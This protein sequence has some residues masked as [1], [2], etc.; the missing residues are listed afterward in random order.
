MTQGLV[1]EGAVDDALAYLHT[2]GT[3][4][5]LVIA[6]P[7]WGRGDL[8]VNGRPVAADDPDAEALWVGFA[9][10]WL[11]RLVPLL[12]PTAAV[13]VLICEELRSTLR[14]LMKGIF[15]PLGLVELACEREYLLD[16]V[17]AS[18]EPWLL[19]AERGA[20]AG[21]EASRWSAHDCG[22]SLSD[23][24]GHGRYRTRGITELEL[25]IGRHNAFAAKPPA[26]YTTIISHWLPS[27]AGTVL[28]PFAG[29]GPL[30]IAANQLGIGWIALERQP[31]VQVLAAVLD[32][33]A[34]SYATVRL[35]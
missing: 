1:V 5:D 33:L 20:S 14:D 23:E 35:A 8:V 2:H 9:E 29:S 10:Q 26:L 15:T 31:E 30:A 24:P 25:L 11:Q 7:P 34:I 6:D 21:V 22:M 28:D 12:S 3:V 16:G 27:G 13:A 32:R 17:R 18:D 19:V 4:V